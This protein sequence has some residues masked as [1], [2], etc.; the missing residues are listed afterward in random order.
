MPAYKN[1]KK[2]RQYTDELK[3]K[4][5]KLTHLNGVSVKG[6]A[7]ALDIHP[8]MLSR[9][10]EEYREGKIV[11]D[12][13]KMVSKKPKALSENERIRKLEK[14]VAD[15][16]EE[17][18]LPKPT[19]TNQHWA[20]DLT[21]IRVGK[22]WLYLAAVIDLYSRRIVGWSLGKQKTV[23]LTKASLQMALRNRR[24]APGLIFHTDRGVEYHAYIAGHQ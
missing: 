17:N 16:K 22:R 5:V 3:A 23:S 4:A 2:T 20:A 18:D 24:P 14:H 11:A 19:A 12:K 15:L 1:P 13:R 8:F 21:Y 6:V 7:E 10:R 9:W